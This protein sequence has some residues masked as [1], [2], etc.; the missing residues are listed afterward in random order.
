[1]R[2]LNMCNKQRLIIGM[3]GAS[4]AIL[5]IEILKALRDNLE[6]ETHLVISRGAELTI[7]QETDYKIA[8]VINL[9]NQV[10]DIN[11]I[12]ASIA[13]GTF[14]TAGMIIVPCSMKTVAGIANGYSDNLLLRAADVTIKEH[15]KVVVVPRES[16]LSPIH[17]KNLLVLAQTGATII[18]PLVTYYH[19]PSTIEEMNRQIIG[20]I[21][22]QLC[23]GALEINRWGK[24]H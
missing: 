22:D 12:A 19:R 13:S 16:P 6:W 2:K 9:A 10:Y 14:K 7:A 17:L 21:L 20:R 18:P 23:I 4:G 8:Q 3:S 15:R 24:P 5:G 1:M 11:D